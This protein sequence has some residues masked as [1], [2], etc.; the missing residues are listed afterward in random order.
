MAEP[1]TQ[2][3]TELAGR[4]RV[5]RIAASAVIIRT[6]IELDPHYPTISDKER[7]ALEQVRA[8]LEAEAPVGAAADPVADRQRH[9]RD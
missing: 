6:L 1:E 5:P 7:Q 2:R 3:L 4:L 9:S 8:E